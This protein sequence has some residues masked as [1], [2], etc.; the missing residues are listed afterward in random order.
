MLSSCLLLVS[1]ATC[2]ASAPVWSSTYSV[3]GVLSIPYAEIEVCLSRY[4]ITHTFPIFAQEPFT[5]WLDREGGRSRIDYYG[6]MV[7][8]FQRGDVEQF[9][10]MVKIIPFTNEVTVLASSICTVSQVVTNEIDCFQADGDQDNKV[11]PQSML[12]DISDFDLIGDELKNG[13]ACQK[14]HKIEKVAFLFLFSLLS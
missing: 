5:A 10:T 9:G 1:L 7:K 6:G 2:Q 3:Q 14:W 4:L 11:E 13:Q 8:T 12:P